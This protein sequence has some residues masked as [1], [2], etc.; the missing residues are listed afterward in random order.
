MRATLDNVT[1]IDRQAYRESC[2]RQVGASAAPIDRDPEYDARFLDAV[3]TELDALR[4]EAGFSWLDLAVEA[5]LHPCT[6]RA[7]IKGYG[8][9]KSADS[10]RNGLSIRTLERAIAAFGLTFTEFAQRV[11][12]RLE[13]DAT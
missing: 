12:A 5:D 3:R 1:G 4:A 6:L 2:R 7:T 10:I 11:D 13:M 9:L 8:K